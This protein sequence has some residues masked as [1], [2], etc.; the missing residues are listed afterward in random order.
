MLGLFEEIWD[1]LSDFFEDLFEHLFKGRPKEPRKEKTIIVEGV[2]R[3]VRPAY[4]FAE[5]VDSLLRIIFG[6]SV[7]IS[8]LTATFLGF[9]SL[10]DLVEVLIFTFWGRVIA[11]FIGASYLLI[12][13]WKTLHLGKVN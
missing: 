1:E 3:T 2:A 5:R 4:L 9:A 7:V 12:G 11:F 6:A 10:G 13:L 8:A